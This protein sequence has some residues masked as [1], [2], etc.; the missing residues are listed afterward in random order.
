M[1]RDLWADERGS[2]EKGNPVG[3]WHVEDLENDKGE[4]FDIDLNKEAFTKYN[5]SVIWQM[6]YN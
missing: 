4:Y 3:V 2:E 6:I 5:G 1:N